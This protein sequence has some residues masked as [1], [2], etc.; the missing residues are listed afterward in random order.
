MSQAPVMPDHPKRHRTG[1][2][3]MLAAGIVFNTVGIATILW[4]MPAP[5][6]RKPIPKPY[7]VI[8]EELQTKVEPP[9]QQILDNQKQLPA[10]LEGLKALQVDITTIKTDVQSLKKQG[11]GPIGAEPQ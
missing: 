2:H 10:I 5:E 9:L 3:L 1:A 7:Q 11:S 4:I 6:I 8:L